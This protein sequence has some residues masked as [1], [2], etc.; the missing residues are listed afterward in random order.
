MDIHLAQRCVSLSVDI[1]QLC[2]PLYPRQQRHSETNPQDEF[3]TCTS[4]LAE[5]GLKLLSPE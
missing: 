1:T 5:L 2:G 3:T 4:G